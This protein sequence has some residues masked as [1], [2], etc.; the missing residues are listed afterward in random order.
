MFHR[1]YAW[2]SGFQLHQGIIFRPNCLRLFGF[3]VCLK[4]SL[5]TLLVTIFDDYAVA[6]R[7]SMKVEHTCLLPFSVLSSFSECFC[8]GVALSVLWAKISSHISQRCHC[9]VIEPVVTKDLLSKL[10][11]I[12]NMRAHFESSFVK[13]SLPFQTRHTLSTDYFGGST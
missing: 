3:E 13:A 1:R 12:Q 6:C 7:C 10:N 4:K 5:L 8:A 11:Q 2:I 9:Q